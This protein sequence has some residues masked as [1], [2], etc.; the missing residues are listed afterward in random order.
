MSHRIRCEQVSDLSIR[1]RI[2]TEAADIIF[3]EILFYFILR[4]RVNDIF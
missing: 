2:K 3:T 4:K 1:Y